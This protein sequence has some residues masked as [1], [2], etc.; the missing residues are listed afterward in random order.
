MH[1]ALAT[2]KY[3]MEKAAALRAGRMFNAHFVD[4]PNVVD[5]DAENHLASP[6]E[7]GAHYA[8]SQD[9]AELYRSCRRLGRKDRGELIG[10]SQQV[11]GR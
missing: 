8:A 9:L 6:A 4:R 11:A 3:P 10:E 1:H 5:R 7:Y 2:M